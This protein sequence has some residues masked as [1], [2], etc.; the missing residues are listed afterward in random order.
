MQWPWD[1]GSPEAVP[2][3]P[4]LPRL[5]GDAAGALC[6]IDRVPRPRLGRASST[7]FT[8]GVRFGRVLDLNFVGGRFLPLVIPQ[9]QVSIVAG[10]WESGLAVRLHPERGDRDQDVG[11]WGPGGEGLGRRF[12]VVSPGVPLLGGNRAAMGS[13]HPTLFYL[14]DLSEGTE[15]EE[16]SCFSHTWYLPFQQWV[17]FG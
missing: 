14:E 3:D 5:V 11:V 13:P 6:V 12:Y 9:A 2:Y 17:M 16:M 4:G 15:W 8:G 10:I 1:R 7:F